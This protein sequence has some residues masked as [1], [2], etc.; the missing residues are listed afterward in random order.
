VHASYDPDLGR[1]SLVPLGGP[2]MTLDLIWNS[3]ALV[4]VIAAVFPP[5]SGRRVMGLN[6]AARGVAAAYRAAFL[7]GPLAR[8]RPA[9][10]RELPP[11]G[12]PTSV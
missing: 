12:R 7:S 10:D 9:E 2:F 5:S 3:A 8:D 1:P 6:L 11:E 4:T